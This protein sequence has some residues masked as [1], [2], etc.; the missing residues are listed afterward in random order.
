ME[1]KYGNYHLGNKT[2]H[3]SSEL[4]EAQLKQIVKDNPVMEKFI[5]IEADD[6]DKQESDS[7]VEVVSEPAKPKQRRKRKSKV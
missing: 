6:N 2:I 5:K 7:N 3:V 1:V 4:T